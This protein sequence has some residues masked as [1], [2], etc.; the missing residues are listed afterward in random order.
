MTRKPLTQNEKLSILGPM[1]RSLG[2]TADQVEEMFAFAM[3]EVPA[4]PPVKGTPTSA[5]D[6]PDF[7][8]GAGSQ[9]LGERMREN[10]QFYINAAMY[11]ANGMS[12]SDRVLMLEQAQALKAV[13][14]LGEW[15]VELEM[16]P[17]TPLGKESLSRT[18]NADIPFRAFYL[19]EAVAKLLE[20]VDA[21]AAMTGD[22]RLFM[23]KYLPKIAESRAKIQKALIDHPTWSDTKIAKTY[24][25]DLT[26][27]RSE[28]ADGRLQR[29][30]VKDGDAD[31]S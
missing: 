15:K 25:Y 6:V 7:M 18:R 10:P 22:L 11:A 16:Y 17:D 14:V 23:Q 3:R 8:N 29:R 30:P 21:P 26:G 24:G 19:L 9:G 4:I 1:I 20:I 31:Q 28:I 12:E 13:R 2:W 27:M 5:K